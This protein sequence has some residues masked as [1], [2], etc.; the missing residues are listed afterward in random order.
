[1][2]A[3]IGGSI[4]GVKETDHQVAMRDGEKITC[5]VYQPETAPS[6]GSPLY[7]MFHGG[8]SVVRLIDRMSGMIA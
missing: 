1:M 6:G 7:V 4:P 3:Q 8:K 2:T 5:R